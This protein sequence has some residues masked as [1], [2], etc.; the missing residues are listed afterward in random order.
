MSTE[1]IDARNIGAGDMKG[2][3]DFSFDEDREHI[4]I[5]LPGR[6]APD[7]LRIQLGAPG[8][9][10]V[11]GWDGNEQAPT[12]TPSIHDVGFWHGFLTAGK[13]ISC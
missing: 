13:L 4:Y 1:S 2:P 9:D 8:G 6:T 5:W 3:G 11:W 10:R 12:I 7:C